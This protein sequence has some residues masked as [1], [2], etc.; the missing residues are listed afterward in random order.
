MHDTSNDWVS[1]I[2]KPCADCL[3][4][5]VDGITCPFNRENTTEEEAR[6]AWEEGGSVEEWTGTTEQWDTVLSELNNEPGSDGYCRRVEEAEQRI[7]ED[8]LS[9][10]V[11]SGWVGLGE[12]MVLEEFSILL[13]TGGPAYRIRGTLNQYGEPDRA[14]LEVQDWGKPW[15]E[16]LGA[17]P[18]GLAEACLTYAR[19]FCWEVN[20]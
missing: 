10:E 7:R 11:R 17:D 5:M 4:E 1:E 15:T 12:E 3:R 18:S 2:G 6:E 16:Y 20:R 9:L 13:G 19:V 14:R 8:A